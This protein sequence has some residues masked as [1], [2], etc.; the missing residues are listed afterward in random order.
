MSLKEKEC[1]EI[2]AKPKA[3]FGIME[4]LAGI[5]MVGLVLSIGFGGLMMFANW[6]D[7]GSIFRDSGIGHE[8]TI[9]YFQFFACVGGTSLVLLVIA[10]CGA[11]GNEQE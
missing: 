4:I 9:R 3:P 1:D 5:G 6:I 7:T 10:I 2:Q 11:G 8:I